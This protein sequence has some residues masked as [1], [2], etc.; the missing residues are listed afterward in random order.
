MDD[1]ASTLRDAL[2]GYDDL[3][4]ALR[5]NLSESDRRVLDLSLASI[6]IPKSASKRKAAVTTA[7][8]S[9]TAT[10]ATS[11]LL[12]SPSPSRRFLGEASDIRFVHSME[13]QFCH[14]SGSDQQM[15][16]V[17]EGRVHSY[18][19]DVSRTPGPSDPSGGRLPPKSTA[20][21]YV[22]IFF[23]TIHIAYPF[24]SEPDFRRQYES[25][26]RSDSLEDFRE[27]WL[28]LLHKRNLDS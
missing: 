4:Q 27:P 24:L 20:D 28:S 22:D 8:S 3:I 5:P 2:A 17:P 21:D 25:F 26:W 15:Q 14:P 9:E 19:Q 16:G 6:H 10:P 1:E 13:S 7:A 23:S 18:E 12:Q 11:R